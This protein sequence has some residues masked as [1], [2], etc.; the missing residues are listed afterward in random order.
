VAGKQGSTEDP[1]KKKITVIDS[2]FGTERNGKV[3]RN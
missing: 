3:V 2:Y 1:K